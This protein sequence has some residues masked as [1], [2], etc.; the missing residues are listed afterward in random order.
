M[1]TTSHLLR[2]VSHTVSLRNHIQYMYSVNGTLTNTVGEC[3]GKCEVL[4]ICNRHIP[5]GHTSRWWPVQGAA[6]GPNGH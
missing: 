1:H 4:L 2:Y 3:A 6:H 5:N